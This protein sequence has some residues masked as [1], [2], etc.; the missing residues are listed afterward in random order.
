M[1]KSS[2]V[3]L[4]HTRMHL[5]HCIIK[6]DRR[7]NL[8]HG[9]KRCLKWKWGETKYKSL[10]KIIYQD[11][12]CTGDTYISAQSSEIVGE[13]PFLLSASDI[14]WKFDVI[15][16]NTLFKM[17]NNTQTYFG[18]DRMKAKTT[19][20]FRLELTMDKPW[21]CLPRQFN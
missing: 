11:K 21:F 16:L 13:M 1:E 9:M 20:Q 14:W 2:P 19:S 15:H 7:T 17:K 18:V 6:K 10:S 5:N 8:V 4:T 3:L 12:L